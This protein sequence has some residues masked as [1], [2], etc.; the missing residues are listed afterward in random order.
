MFLA[1]IGSDCNANYG[2]PNPIY[3]A[4]YHTVWIDEFQHFSFHITPVTHST[5]VTIY[6]IDTI[7]D[8][9]GDEIINPKYVSGCQTLEITTIYFFL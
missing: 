4:V 7:M 3:T 5:N 6:N 8:C 1:K 2:Y 9:F